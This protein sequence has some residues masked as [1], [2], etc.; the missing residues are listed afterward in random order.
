[1]RAMT[2]PVITSRFVESLHLF[3]TNV[4]LNSVGLLL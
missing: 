2:T 3:D 4:L 1:M